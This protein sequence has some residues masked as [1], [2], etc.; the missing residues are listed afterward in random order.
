MLQDARAEVLFRVE[1]GRR[2]PKPLRVDVGRARV[3]ARRAPADVDVMPQGRRV[4]RHLSPEEDGGE[5]HDVVQVLA[6]VVGVVGDETLLR[7]DVRE[8]VPLGERL[9]DH[10]EGVH[11]DGAELGLGD[12]ASLRIEKRRRAVPGLADDDGVRRAHELL[13]HLLGDGVE[14][15]TNNVEGSLVDSHAP[16]SFESSRAPVR[17]T[18]ALHPGGTRVVAVGSSMTARP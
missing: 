13:P 2:N 6:A 7:A 11:V 16:S 15:V 9:E 8:V 4:G 17:A 12:D 18:S 3:R 5:D 14:P 1:A 10:P